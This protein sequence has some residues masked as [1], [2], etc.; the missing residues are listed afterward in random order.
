MR[1]E[2]D[3]VPDLHRRASI[4]YEQRGEL[5]DA[6]R[7]AL[8]GADYERAADMIE[9]AI[10][11]LRQARQEGTMRRWF[12]Q[13]PDEVFQVRPVLSVGYVGALMATGESA[14]VEVLL[15]GAERWLEPASDDQQGPHGAPPAMVV[16]D[17]AEFRRLPS[18]VA[19]YRAAQAQMN[20][21]RSRTEAFAHRAFDL[22]GRGDPLGRGAAAGFLALAHWWGGDLEVA[23]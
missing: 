12:E 20:G 5:F 11:G 21:D 4:W 17:E 19:L 6:I 7:H 2:P 10:P 14:D 18:A 15:R 3:R 1:E 9:P 16:V 23:A 13:L 8:A 22:A